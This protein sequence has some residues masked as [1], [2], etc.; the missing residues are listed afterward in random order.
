VKINNVITNGRRRA[1]EVETNRETYLFPYAKCDPAP[2][3]ADRVVSVYPDPEMG[4]AGFTYELESGAE[5]SVHLDS[6][7][8]V[9]RD[10]EYMADLLMYQL[11]IDAQKRLAASGEKVRDVA[12]ALATSPAQLY[13]LV[14]QT[15]YTKS[16][17]QLVALLNYL[18]C[19]V[20]VQVTRSPRA[21]R[22]QM[23]AGRKSK[24]F[25][26]VSRKVQKTP[27]GSL[28]RASRVTTKA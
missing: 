14:D 25:M 20:G 26:R 16:F 19:D 12:A 6:V 24:P 22:S 7:R 27:A 10:P 2:N 3:S 13:R 4:L 17:R 11:S 9:N 18:G 21:G 5:G 15:N 23:T 28:N 1:F 8:E